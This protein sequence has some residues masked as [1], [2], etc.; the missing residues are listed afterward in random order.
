LLNYTDSNSNHNNNNN[1]IVNKASTISKFS[2]T[3]QQQQQQ[4]NNNNNNNITDLSSASMLINSPQSPAAGGSY[5]LNSQK[6]FTTISGKAT[7]NNTINTTPLETG[8]TPIQS[9]NA[10]YE[11]RGFSSKVASIGGSGSVVSDETSGRFVY[12]HSKSVD[13]SDYDQSKI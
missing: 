7:G 3:K 1:N 13:L 10:V 4:R 8:S 5:L 9:K 2:T 11:V 6:K 12:N